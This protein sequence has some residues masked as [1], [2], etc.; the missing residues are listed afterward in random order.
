[1]RP[2]PKRLFTLGQTIRFT[3]TDKVYN[4]FTEVVI[5]IG[6]KYVVT[7]HYCVIDMTTMTWVEHG[8]QTNQKFGTFEII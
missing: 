3:P 5:R 1:M 2:I 4:S 6:R 7:E 8:R